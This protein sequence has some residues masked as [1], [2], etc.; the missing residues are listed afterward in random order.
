MNNGDTVSMVGGDMQSAV[1]TYNQ[2]VSDFETSS[3]NINAAAENLMLTWKGSGSQ[4]FDAAVQ[5]WRQ[6][7]KLISSD[8]EA[9]ANAMTQAH[10]AITDTD[11]QIAKAFQGFN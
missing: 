7:M 11:T 9:I 8:L 6:D 3:Q 10:I 2:K 5:K 4:S 1:N